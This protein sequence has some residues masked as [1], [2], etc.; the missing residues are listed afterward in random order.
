ML[1][2]IFKN[3]VEQWDDYYEWIH[4]IYDVKTELS[5]DQLKIAYNAF[6]TNHMVSLGIEVN[7]HYPK[8][9]LTDSYNTKNKKIVKKG[10]KEMS[11]EWWLEKNYICKKIEN[12]GEIKI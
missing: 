4:S 9:I 12:Y 2:I 7:P 3:N 10:F 6:M 1:I 11:F 8:T 5:G